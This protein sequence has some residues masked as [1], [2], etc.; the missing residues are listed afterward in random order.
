MTEFHYSFFMKHKLLFAYVR[1]RQNF[2]DSDARVLPLSFNVTTYRWDT[3]CT[4]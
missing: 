3:K 4:L 1:L 2:V